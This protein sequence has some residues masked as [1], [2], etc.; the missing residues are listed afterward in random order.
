[1]P[2]H[3]FTIPEVLQVLKNLGHDVD[4]GA[5]MEIAFTGSTT[6]EHTCEPVTSLVEFAKRRDSLHATFNGG[7]REKE[8]NEAFH[9]GMDT[10]FNCIDAEVKG[11]RRQA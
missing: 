3:G 10:V 5:C 1:M 8:T 6:N 11:E 4:C 9:H 2:K 7:H